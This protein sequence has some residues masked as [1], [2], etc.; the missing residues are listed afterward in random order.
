MA[1]KVSE[2]VQN[3]NNAIRL[4]NSLSKVEI[5]GEISNYHGPNRSGHIY[6]DL[7]DDKAIIKCMMFASKC[8]YEYKQIIREGAEVV[9]YGSLNYHQQFGLSFVFER[10]DDGGEGARMRALEELRRE[11]EELGMF[12]EMYKKPIPR[13]P[14]TIGLITALS[15][16]AISD[17]VTN[18]RKNNPYVR[19]VVA[20]ALME[21]DGAVSEVVRA[22]KL[23]DKF[24]PDVILLT[25][26]GGS[27]DS[28]WTFNEREV[29]QAV[30]DCETPIV[31]AIGH[32][33]DHSLTDDIADHHESTPTGAALFLTGEFRQ[34]LEYL[35]EAPDALL[36][37][38]NSHIKD[39]RVRVRE[40]G[41]LVKYNSPQSRLER[42][43]KELE[44]Y[45]VTL[46]GLMDS[47]LSADKAKLDKA[48]NLLPAY[49]D[50]S[51]KKAH[52]SRDLYV[53]KLEGLS[54]VSRLKG[55]YSYVSDSKGK[56]IRSVSGVKKGD[57]IKIRVSDGE[58][59]STVESLARISEEENGSK[60]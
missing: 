19:I 42:R 41:A 46:N 53:G 38:M 4:S 21:G 29:A 27:K 22:I 28:L 11:L 31:S 14:K 2:L 56:N 33:R 1:F 34:L 49:M 32:D 51:L 17:V 9:L 45:G 13:F 15:G 55:G 60:G 30:F 18:A 8:T 37:L 6:F 3:L 10:I 25:R 26:G 54:P 57:E 58:I 59:T 24:S 40:A 35:D 20:P 5:E 39:S 48:R 12:D 7:K 44:K 50:R 52:Y 23:M 47:K 36:S 43:K 16:A